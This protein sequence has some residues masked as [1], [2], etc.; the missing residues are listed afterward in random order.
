MFK[1]EPIGVSCAHLVLEKIIKVGGLL[2]PKTNLVLLVSDGVCK[3]L[4]LRATD[5][6]VKIR[7]QP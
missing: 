3:L 1:I 4:S 6:S 2:I 7:K 5:Y